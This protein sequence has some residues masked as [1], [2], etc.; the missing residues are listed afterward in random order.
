MLRARLAKTRSGKI[1]RRVLRA[2]EWGAKIGEI[3]TLDNDQASAP[4]PVGYRQLPRL[5]FFV[6]S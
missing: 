5:C 3:S 1:M 6:F 2:Q 4:S